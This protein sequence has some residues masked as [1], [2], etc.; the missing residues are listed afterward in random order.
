MLGSVKFGKKMITSVMLLSTLAFFNTTV[1]A[2][3]LSPREAL[4]NA[5]GKTETT[6]LLSRSAKSATTTTLAY[7][8][9]TEGTPTVYVF[10][11]K[12]GGY[13]VVAA[14]DAV[15]NGLLGYTD[16]GS[17]VGEDIPQNI[18]WVLEQY[19]D[20]IAFAAA[21]EEQNT[22]SEPVGT[23]RSAVAPIVTTHW[24][25][26]GVYNK[27]CPELDGRHCPTGCVATAMAQVMFSHRYPETGEGS[28]HYRLT[29]FKDYLDYDF[30]K[31]TFD[32]DAMAIGSSSNEECGNAIANLMVAC[33]MA[34]KT[35]YKL[36]GS[37]SSLLK[38]AKAL[39]ANFGYDKYMAVYERDYFTLERWDEMLYNELAAGRPVIYSGRS[40]VDGGHAFVIDGYST[41]GYYHVNWGWDGVYDGYFTI[42]A[43]DPR[44]NNAGFDYD[45]QMV[46]GIRP[47]TE[48]SVVRPVLVFQGDM[49]L[50]SMNVTRNSYGDIKVAASRGIVSNSVATT[51]VT[52]GV[53]LTST[54][55]G[56]VSYV[57]A[58][59]SKS[60]ISGQGVTN[61]VMRQSAFPKSGCFLM[62][63]A[64]MGEDGQWY[65]ME[66]SSSSEKAMYVE[67]E[68]KS[69]AFTPE[70]EVIAAESVKDIQVTYLAVKSGDV[71]GETFDIEAHFCNNSTHNYIKY[72][73]PTLMEN[74]TSVAAGTKLTLE[75]DAMEI[76]SSEWTCTLNE[77]VEEGTY[78][79]ALVDRKSNVIGTPIDVKVV[80]DDMNGLT[81]ITSDDAASGEEVMTEVYT[82]DGRQVAAYQPG[83]AID[84]APGVYVLSHRMSDGSVKVEKK[85]IR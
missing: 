28:V 56:S 52:F 85:A 21:Q 80:K 84:V 35:N 41:D 48:T 61:Y 15:P 72:L 4:E 49:T 3:Q 12:N 11:R 44:G 14:N 77:E 58:S 29:N 33:G 23:V 76:N 43:L 81:I 68:A 19:G 74:G 65:E 59:S 71:S 73:T 17:F 54:E 22:A 5:V 32:W 38:A 75:L 9:E 24:G 30:S 47:A 10:T 60:L 1:N 62:E 51:T 64:V 50:S 63:P 27:Y 46:V 55:D 16:T 70:S 25:Q 36:T 78:K 79:L 37:G 20:Q 42:T 26:T 67:C 57:A 34:A 8:V 31:T 66:I 18:G 6:R 45:E 83:E 40:D 7:T 53:K 69:F 39:A 82:L 2:R 13:W